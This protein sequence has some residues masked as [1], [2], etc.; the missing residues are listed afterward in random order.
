MARRR[1]HETKKERETRRK[2]VAYLFSRSV[3]HSLRRHK[4]MNGREFIVFCPVPNRNT[5]QSELTPLHTLT[6]EAMQK[7][8]V[9]KEGKIN[10]ALRLCTSV[11]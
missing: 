11:I 5:P 9:L 10:R 2:T 4:N 3:E 7:I 6:Y 1:Y 8:V